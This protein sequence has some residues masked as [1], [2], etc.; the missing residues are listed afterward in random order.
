MKVHNT[1]YNIVNDMEAPKNSGTAATTEKPSIVKPPVKENT[2]IPPAILKNS[3]YI[4][5]GAGMLVGLTVSLISRK[6]Y[7]INP[8]IGGLIGFAGNEFALKGN[9]KTKKTE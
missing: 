8:L 1:Y 4:S 6:N 2:F 9:K 7:I 3:M 5:I